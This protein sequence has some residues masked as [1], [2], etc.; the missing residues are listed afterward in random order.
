MATLNVRLGEVDARLVRE[1][2]RRGVSI[3]DL[4]RSALRSEAERTTTREALDVDALSAEMT[5]R[6]PTPAAATPRRVN[7]TDR[8]QVRKSIAE[9]LRKRRP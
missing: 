9:K 5:R 3:S 4:V 8:K 6:Y 1:L 2:K 7:A